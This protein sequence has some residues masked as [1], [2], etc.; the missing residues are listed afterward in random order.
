MIRDLAVSRP[1]KMFGPILDR[2]VVKIGED[3]IKT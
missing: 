1:F 2:S 3:K